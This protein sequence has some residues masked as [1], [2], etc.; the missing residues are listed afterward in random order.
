MERWRCLRHDL[1]SSLERC[2]R[3]DANNGPK[4]SLMFVVSR[5]GAS[6]EASRKGC[7]VCDHRGELRPRVRFGENRMKV[8]F[9]RRRPFDGD[10]PFLFG[11]GLLSDGLPEACSCEQLPDS[12][13]VITA[14]Q[15]A[16]EIGCRP[17]LEAVEPPAR[18]IQIER[19]RNE[20]LT[21]A[22]RPG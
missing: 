7:V 17:C 8:L 5:N 15:A 1:S 19:M 13:V 4:K 14:L 20:V 21:P 2:P 11:E 22:C 3:S 16:D 9:H 6:F 12:L 18:P 10:P